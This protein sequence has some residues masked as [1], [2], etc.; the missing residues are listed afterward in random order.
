[1]LLQRASPPGIEP[2]LD[3]LQSRGPATTTEASLRER[4]YSRGEE[5]R[6]ERSAKYVFLYGFGDKILHTDSAS[7]PIGGVYNCK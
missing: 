5:R 2:G 1:M 7:K 6:G 4:A 3:G